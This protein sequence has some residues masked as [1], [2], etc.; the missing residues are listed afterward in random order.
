MRQAGTLTNERDALRF[1]AWL[2]AQRI[3]AHAEKEGDAWAIWIRDEDHLKKA[4]EALE[5]YRID[6]QNAKYRGAE[7]TAEAV[8]RE[9]EAK[10]RRAHENVVEMRGRWAKSGGMGGAPP[11]RC[12]LVLALIGLSVVIFLFTNTPGQA[13]ITDVERTLLFVDPAAVRQAAEEADGFD[14]WTS[15]RGG[16]IWRLVTPMMIHY[17]IMHI[18]FNMLVLFS[19]GGQVED[20]R[21]SLF[22][23]LLVLVL[24][25]SSNVGQVLEY[26]FREIAPRFGGMSGVNYGLF[27][28]LLIKTQFDNRERYLLSPLTTF[29]LLGWFF[30][31]IGGQFPPLDT[32]LPGALTRVAN[33]A[34]AVGF[35]LGMALA[36][37]PIL[38]RKAA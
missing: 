29:I 25:V 7:R 8:L 36:Y 23:A 9:E 27:G 6:P 22:L 4:R 11:R 28:Y 17:G 24:A 14:Y 35:F 38:V 37:A 33:S 1:A 16:Q 18:A 10:R 20:R 21:G 15:I 34:H 31:S 26:E 12:P 2:V 5:H 13:G 3:E 19:F 32:I 30:L